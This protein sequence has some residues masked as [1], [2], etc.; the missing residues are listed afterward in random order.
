MNIDV[1]PERGRPF[2]RTSS[3]VDRE[4]AEWDDRDTLISDR[5]AVTIA[6]WFMSPAPWDMPFTTLAQ[7]GEADSTELL[8]SIRHELD[9]EPTDRD[10]L[11]ALR[12]WVGYKVATTR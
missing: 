5:A 11:L 3:E 8:D 6:S 2:H 9:N 7:K 1:A 4:V 10:A 12:R